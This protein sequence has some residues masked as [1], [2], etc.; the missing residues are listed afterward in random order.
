MAVSGGCKWAHP[1]AQNFLNF[2]LFFGIV[3]KS[4]LS[5]A[6]LEGWCP[7]LGGILDPPLAVLPMLTVYEKLDS[8]ATLLICYLPVSD[9]THTLPRKPLFYCNIYNIYIFFASDSNQGSDY[10]AILFFFDFKF[11][12]TNLK[13]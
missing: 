2:M 7:L 5:L 10:I 1:K 11:Y 13:I 9:F 6:P 3:W 8:L 12:M 4:F